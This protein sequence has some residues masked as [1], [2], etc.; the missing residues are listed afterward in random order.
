MFLGLCGCGLELA[1]VWENIIKRVDIDILRQSNTEYELYPMSHRSSVRKRLF[2]E[3]TQATSYEP[4]RGNRGQRT[5][6][7]LPD[8]RINYLFNMKKKGS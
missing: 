1:F 7:S 5:L 8:G 4:V 2:I 3:L 6:R